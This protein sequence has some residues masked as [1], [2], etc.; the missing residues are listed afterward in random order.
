VSS[1]DPVPDQELRRL[2]ERRVA[3]RRGLIVHAGLYLVVNLGLAALNLATSPH[4]LWF[5][6]PVFGWGIGLAAHAWAVLAALSDDQ[7]RA[8]QAEMDRLRAR[9]R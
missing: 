2:A 1:P 4:Y 3:A 5:L 6:W 8:V 9:G 7:E